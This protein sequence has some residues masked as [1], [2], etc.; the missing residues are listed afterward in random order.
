MTFPGCC[1]MCG[2]RDVALLIRGPSDEDD[3]WVL[4]PNEKRGRK[5]PLKSA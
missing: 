5:A 2:I 4:G 1:A 3:C